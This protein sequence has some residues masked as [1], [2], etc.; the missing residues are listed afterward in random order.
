[1]IL[2]L[3]WFFIPSNFPTIAQ[4][5]PQN[6]YFFRNV[7]G[8]EITNSLKGVKLMVIGLGDIPHE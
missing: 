2:T 5:S 6:F 7:G 3:R 1:M 8:L 4:L